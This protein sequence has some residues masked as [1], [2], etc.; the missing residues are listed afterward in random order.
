MVIGASEWLLFATALLGLLGT[1]L[2]ALPG[3]GLIFAAAIIYAWLK[4]WSVLSGGDLLILGG[5][6]AAAYAADLW[7]GARGA[8]RSGAGRAG[9]LGAMIGAFGG[10]LVLGPLGL[11]LGPLVGALIGELLRGQGW[12]T[13]LKAGAGASLGAVLAL[14]ARTSIAV[15]MLLYLVWQVVRR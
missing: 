1:V 6:N 7:L 12:R 4:R 2:P 14:L 15:I 9:M 5:L 10:V 13:A 11:L 3:T 8:R